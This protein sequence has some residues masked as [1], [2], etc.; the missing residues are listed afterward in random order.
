MTAKRQW[1]TQLVMSRELWPEHEVRTLAGRV[2]GEVDVS[3]ESCVSVNIISST[4]AAAAERRVKQ[5][6]KGA[7]RLYKKRTGKEIR[8]ER[9]GGH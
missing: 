5:F 9:D 2:G 3:D 8:V 7:L 1:G 4:S 6:C